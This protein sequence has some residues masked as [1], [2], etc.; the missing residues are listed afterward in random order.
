M[1]FNRVFAIAFIAHC[2]LAMPA[3]AART[4]STERDVAPPPALGFA[5]NPALFGTHENFDADT[6]R[7]AQWND[8]M[9]RTDAEFGAGDHTCTARGQVHCVPQEWSELIAA[10]RPMPLRQKIEYA[11]AAINR[12][13]Y[14]TTAANWHRTMYWETPF[15]FLERGGQC[16]DYAI[17]KYML[18][19]QAGVPAAALRMVVLRATAI[20]ADHA[21]LVAYVGGEALLLDNLRSNVISADAETSY[22]PYYSINETGWWLHIGA[23]AQQSNF[24]TARR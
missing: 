19:R 1:Q 8:M 9:R 24:T 17:A 6:S 21:V 2:L 18:L 20:G 15:Q 4:P 5:P 10:L 22:R 13:P 11:N 3:F 7:F 12:H 23:R 14:V 16:Q